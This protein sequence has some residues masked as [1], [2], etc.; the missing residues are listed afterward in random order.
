MQKMIFQYDINSS[1]LSIDTNNNNL[2]SLG[3]MDRIARIFT[4]TSPF[5]QYGQTKN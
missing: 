3:T 2:M 4:I 1:I 5:T